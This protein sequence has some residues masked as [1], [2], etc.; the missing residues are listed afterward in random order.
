M[1]ARPLRVFVL[2]GRGVYTTDT[3]IGTAEEL[4]SRNEH[5]LDGLQVLAHIIVRRVQNT[6]RLRQQPLKSTHAAAQT[7]IAEQ[8]EPQHQ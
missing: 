2:G 3:K 7:T 6:E 8:D 4:T 1:P 5:A